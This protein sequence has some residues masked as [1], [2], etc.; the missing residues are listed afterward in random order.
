MKALESVAAIASRTKLLVD[1]RDRATSDRDEIGQWLTDTTLKSA[2]RKS[3]CLMGILI[4]LEEALVICAHKLQKNAKDIKAF[5]EFEIASGYIAILD[6]ENRNLLILGMGKF[7]LLKFE[8]P[9]KA[10][11]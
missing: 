5:E 2:L 3:R 8:Y 9:L 7:G 6:K 1:D 11:F 10:S 4:P